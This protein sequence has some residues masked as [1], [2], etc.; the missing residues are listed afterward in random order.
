MKRIGLS[1]AIIITTLLALLGM[2][3][4]IGCTD[5]RLTAKDGTVLVARSMEYALDLK[6]NLRTST[7]NRTF[8]NTSANGKPGLTWQSKYGYLYLDGNNFDV[9]LDGMNEAG[10]SFEALYLPTLAEYQTVPA[11]KESQ[12][13]PYF[14]IGDWIL[15]NFKTVAEVKSALATVYVFAQQIPGLGNMIF[16][17]HF[18]IYDNS[19]KGLIIEYIEGK[20]ITY[21]SIGVL[22][23]SPSYH[24]QTTNLENYLHLSPLNPKPIA[25]SGMTFE[26][27]GQGFGM[28]GLPGDIT[29][30]SRFV[31]V[32]VL[33]KTA[34]PAN[35]ASDV[36]NLAQH[37]IN[38]VDV[39]RG[40]AREPFSGNYIDET[41]QWTVFKDLTHKILYYH[42]YADLTLRSVAMDK[43]D[44]SANAPRLMMPIAT[45]PTILDISAD[46][47]THKDTSHTH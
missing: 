46:Y 28:L 33:A 41:T 18:A 45:P 31:K 3:D 27:N 20:L 47:L 10:L 17:L 14:A 23:N 24:W 6:S 35:D 15:G 30:P 19:G 13:L 36:L 32:A 44:F 8:T 42:T 29:P 11:G 5:F 43:I 38:N 12:A 40:I 26:A 16:P 21:D 4:A 2:I 22:T 25:I 7:R 9:A 37:I 34:I 1:I 39:V